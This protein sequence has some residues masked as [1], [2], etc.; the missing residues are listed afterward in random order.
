MGAIASY[1][2]CV[3]DEADRRGYSFDKSKIVNKRI[4][5]KISVTAGQVE[6]EHKHLLRKLRK[7]DKNQYKRLKEA[8]KINLHPLFHKVKGSVEEWE[9]L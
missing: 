5:T 3:V 2:R 1:L 4:T 9:I 6:F 8:A 7:R